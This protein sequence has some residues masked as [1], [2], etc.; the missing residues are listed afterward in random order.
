MEIQ[1]LKD[2]IIENNKVEDIL[3][4][5]EF[6]EIKRRTDYWSCA[7]P[8][9]DNPNGLLVYDNLNV[10]SNTRDLRLVS[11]VQDFITVVQFV[12]DY[13]L[14]E[15]IKYL[16]NCLGIG[17][18]DDLDKE[19]PACIRFTKEIMKECRVDSQQELVRL[20]PIDRKVLEYYHTPCV[21]DIFAKDGISYQT[22]KEF[23]IGYD[24]LT[25]RITIPIYTAYGDLVGV[26]GRKYDDRLDDINDNK[27]YPLF[28]YPKGSILFG[29]N[30]T[31][32]YIRNT[33][34]VYVTEAEKGVMQ[35]WSSGI[36]NSCATGGC[37][38]SKRQADELERMGVKIILAYDQDVLE[39]QL[40]GIRATFS[41]ETHIYAMIDKNGLLGAKDSPTDHM[42]IFRRMAKE[43][44]YEI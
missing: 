21:N 32:S 24:D 43:N 27:Y 14:Y 23:E 22:Q 31:L 42:D 8:D 18:Y 6:H 13:N 29:L 9:G 30:K 20:K 35:L 10:L 40:Q 36:Y 17:L 11:N 25:N 5:L 15:A 26:K 19:V 4:D 12:K 7:W 2:Y 3:S 33:G 39:G 44:V 34:F 28:P 38:I 37:N 1:D 16:C 41:R